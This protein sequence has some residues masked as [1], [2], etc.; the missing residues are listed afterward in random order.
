MLTLGI[1]NEI[2]KIAEKGQ[3]RDRVVVIGKIDGKSINVSVENCKFV[4]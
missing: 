3:R 2:D 4:D 1:K